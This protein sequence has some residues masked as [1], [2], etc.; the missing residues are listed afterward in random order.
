MGCHIQEHS[1]SLSLTSLLC[2]LPLLP[3]ELLRLQQMS[4]PTG[5]TD[6]RQQLPTHLVCNFDKEAEALRGLEEQPGGDVLAEVLGLGARL[7][8][9]GLGEGGSLGSGCAS[10]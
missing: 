10:N 9:E 3:H 5:Q 4:Q 7:H 8:L 2:L 1:S 6:S